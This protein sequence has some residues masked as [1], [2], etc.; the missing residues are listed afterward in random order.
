MTLAHVFGQLA[1]ESSFALRPRTPTR[2][3]NASESAT[4]SIDSTPD[5]EVLRTPIERPSFAGVGFTDPGPESPLFHVGLV[6]LN[7]VPL[8]SKYDFP[9]ISDC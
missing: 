9:S 8:V 6:S 1:S 7:T 2:R 5:S 4:S 3:R